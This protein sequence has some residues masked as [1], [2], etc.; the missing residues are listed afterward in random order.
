MRRRPLS[1]N[2]S[3]PCRLE[4]RP[5]RW[6]PGA[7]GTAAVLGNFSLQWSALPQGLAAVAGA[8]LGLI[9]LLQAWAWMRQPPR[10]LIVPWGQVPASVD[11]LPV[12][13]LQVQWRG[14]LAWVSWRR[15]PRRRTCLLFCPD[16]LPPARRRELRLAA[17]SRAVPPSRRQWHHS[18]P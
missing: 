18:A 15:G 3:S 17:D 12:A 7:L 10:H 11:G 2:A 13:T 6:V 5:S 1:S 14:P 9:A 8:L 16:T 4:W